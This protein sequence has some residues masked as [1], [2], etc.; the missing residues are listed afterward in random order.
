M[1]DLVVKAFSSSAA[2]MLGERIRNTGC[3]VPFSEMMSTSFPQ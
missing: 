3:A 1:G 2:A